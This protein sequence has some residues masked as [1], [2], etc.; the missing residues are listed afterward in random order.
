LRLWEGH[1]LRIII[2]CGPA[3][4]QLAEIVVANAT[5][6]LPII[7]Q[8]GIAGTMALLRGAELVVAGDSGPLHLANALGT[9]VVG[10]FGPT[11][12]D[13][14]GPYGGRDMVVRNV[15]DSETTYKREN[16]YSES[17]CSITIDQVMEAIEKRLAMR[18]LE[19]GGQRADAQPAKYSAQDTNRQSGSVTNDA[20]VKPTG[21]GR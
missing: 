12:P 10:L 2:N 3:E 20:F 19:R 11:S 4:A 9:P 8:Y 21:S 15:D 18:A 17:M 7:V 14:N 6:A 16:A 5:F 1:G 13:R